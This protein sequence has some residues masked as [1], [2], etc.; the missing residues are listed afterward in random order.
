MDK[1]YEFIVA[2]NVEFKSTPTSEDSQGMVRRA[3]EKLDTYVEKYH[4]R[5]RA[6]AI[7]ELIFSHD[8]DSDSPNSSCQ[9][10]LSQIKGKF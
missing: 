1:K 10:L 2:D 6:S 5:S 8:S 3:L 4:L 9:D 7:E